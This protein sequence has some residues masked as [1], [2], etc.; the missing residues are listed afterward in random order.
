MLS[1]PLVLAL[2]RPFV[3]VPSL[4]A[5]RRVASH[6]GTDATVFGFG[7]PGPRPP[8]LT[9]MV[10]G[11]LGVVGV[12]AVMAVLR[13]AVLVRRLRGGGVRRVLV[14]VR[15]RGRVVVVVVVVGRRVLRHL[16]VVRVVAVELGLHRVRHLCCVVQVGRVGL[17]GDEGGLAGGRPLGRVAPLG[18]RLPPLAAEDGAQ[19]GAGRRVGAGG[20]AAAA[21]GGVAAAAAAAAGG[22]ATAAAAAGGS[23]SRRGGSPPHV[24][25][26]NDG[27]LQRRETN[28]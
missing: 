25:T 6:Y 13:V 22:V 24:R 8:L 14:V 3:K 23:I 17:V 5:S 16:A 26:A 9:V 19:D 2:V 4:V 15:V 7:R 27:P 20:V 18:G 11:V 21:A 12:L 10:G 28:K 1:V